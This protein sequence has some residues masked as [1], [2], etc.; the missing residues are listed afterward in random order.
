MRV[1]IGEEGVAGRHMD[2]VRLMTELE[3]WDKRM[4]LFY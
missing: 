3:S 1:G 4:V 2:R